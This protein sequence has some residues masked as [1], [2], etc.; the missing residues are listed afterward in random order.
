LL[1]WTRR[2]EPK[3]RPT[4]WTRPGDPREAIAWLQ[5]RAKAGDTFAP[6]QIVD[7]LVGAGWMGEAIAWLLSRAD[8]GDSTAFWQ[9]VDALE[10]TGRTEQA[11]KASPIR[12]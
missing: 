12:D 9:A 10:K 8:A 11:K 7:L 3:R 4:C 1:S 6:L 5:S 2:G